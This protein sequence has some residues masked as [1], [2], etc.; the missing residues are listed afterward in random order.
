VVQPTA[1]QQNVEYLISQG[2]DPQ[3]AIGMVF[4]PQQGNAPSGYQWTPDGA[5]SPIPGGPA[6]IPTEGER[7]SA[8]Y[9]ERM[10]FAEDL[11]EAHEQQHGVFKPNFWN[12]LAPNWVQTEEAQNYRNAADQWVR[13]KLRKVSGAAISDTEWESEFRTFFPQPGDS[14]SVIAQKRA[15]RLKAE[16]SM[17]T[18][19][20]RAAGSI[21][22]REAPGAGSPSLG[23]GE[24]AEIAPGLTIRRVQ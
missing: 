6:T 5:L 4:G 18:Q 13:A 23:V 9:A 12:K 21:P 1:G 24:S 8:S 15:A 2:M 19:A 16:E 3:Q 14:P 7:S 20:G 10:G 17:R 11:I 22:E